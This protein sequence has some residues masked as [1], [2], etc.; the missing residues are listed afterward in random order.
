MPAHHD[1]RAKDVNVRRL[2]GTLAAAADCGPED[3]PALLLTPGVGARTVRALAMGRR[4]RAWRFLPLHGS[5]ALLARAR[6]KGPPP[7]S[8]SLE[9]L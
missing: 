9:G 7:L 3:F 4:S 5:G 2:R 1:V 8:C 6:R